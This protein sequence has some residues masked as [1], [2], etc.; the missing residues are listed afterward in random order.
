V[1]GAALSREALP[2]A[3]KLTAAICAVIVAA[4]AAVIVI[5]L[6]PVRAPA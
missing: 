4:M 6:R 3:L 2:H 1:F 5:L